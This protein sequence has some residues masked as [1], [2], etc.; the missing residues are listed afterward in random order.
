MS[1]TGITHRKLFNN[2]RTHELP[3]WPGVH[4]CRESPAC[5]ACP[6]SPVSEGQRVEL[7]LNRLATANACTCAEDSAETKRFK[8]ARDLRGLEGEIGRKLTPAEVR[9]ACDEWERLSLPFLEW[10]DEDHFVMLLAE[11]AKVRVPTG[12]GDTLNK[13]L[14]R[15]SKLPDSD[16]P[17]I[18]GYPDARK[19]L[20]KLAALHR[21]ISRLCG[22]KVYFLSYRNAAKVYNELSPQSAHKLSLALERCD[23]IKIV[24][25]G[26]PGLKTRKATEFRYLL[27]LN[28]KVGATDLQQ[29]SASSM[30]A[31]VQA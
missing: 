10:G 18:P 22:G 26:K 19:T 11:V 16:L 5:P 14:E 24:H 3:V 20:R 4:E 8:L 17:V 28:A 6:V 9:R 31:P 15:V 21:E 23:V 25:K 30:Q 12:E 1:T 2:G 13:A 29:R 27:P 7:E